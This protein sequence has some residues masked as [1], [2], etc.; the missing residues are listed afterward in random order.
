MGSAPIERPRQCKS[1]PDRRAEVHEEMEKREHV[2]RKKSIMPSLRRNRENRES[3]TAALV[4]RP[5]HQ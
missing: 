1:P 5:L 2:E 3:F 4:A